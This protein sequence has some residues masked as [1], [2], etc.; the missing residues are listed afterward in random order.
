MTT[1]LEWLSSD[2]ARI[3]IELG[4]VRPD[5]Y[6][7]YIRYSIF[8]DF[9]KR[10]DKATAIQLAADHCRCDGLTIYR[11]IWFFQVDEK[12]TSQ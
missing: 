4:I 11:A 5:I 3:G 9:M 8:C 7:K 6:A 1:R 2:Q 10:N 12:I